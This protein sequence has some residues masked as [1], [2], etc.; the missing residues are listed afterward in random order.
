MEIIQNALDELFELYVKGIKN[1]EDLLDEEIKQNGVNVDKIREALDQNEDFAYEEDFDDSLDD[2]EEEIDPFEFAVLEDVE[3]DIR[4]LSKKDYEHF[5][6]L[7]YLLGIEYYEIVYLDIRNIEGYY[8]EEGNEILDFMDSCTKK[9][10]ID[11]VMD[12]EN[13]YLSEIIATILNDYE[14]DE[15]MKPEYDYMFLQDVLDYDQVQKVFKKFHPNLKKELINLKEY[16]NH[17]DFSDKLVNVKINSLFDYIVTSLIV[18]NS[19]SKQIYFQDIIIAKLNQILVENEELYDE[20][21]LYL[22]KYLYVHLKD[23]KDKTQLELLALSTIEE[24]PEDEVSYYPDV[25]FLINQFYEFDILKHYNKIENI[26][27]E[28]KTKIKKFMG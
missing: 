9:E 19:V 14:V 26:T 21:V 11:A 20:I 27:E 24:N 10:F 17:L 3:K 28:E 8:P 2:L 12:E 4:N 1:N 6:N 15:N 22:T 7:V 13:G 5:C 16:V 25:D 23:K 18:K